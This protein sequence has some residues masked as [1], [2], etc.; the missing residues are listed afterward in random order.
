MT[1]E[2][3]RRDVSALSEGLGPNAEK[4]IAAVAADRDFWREQAL[5]AEAVNQSLRSA[6]R[7]MLAL[8]AEHHQRGHDD[9][10]LCAEV[11]AAQAA[12]GGYGPE[13][14]QAQ[15]DEAPRLDLGA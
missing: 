10:D 15:A 2:D 14:L 13:F 3:D 9:D 12:I 11:Q 4:R 6:L 7:G 8:D 5:A 1:T